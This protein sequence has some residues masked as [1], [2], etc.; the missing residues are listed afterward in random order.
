M[1]LLVHLGVTTHWLPRRAITCSMLSS[2]HQS[3]ILVSRMWMDGWK[4]FHPFLNNWGSS[5]QR[6][7][8]DDIFDSSH[9]DRCLVLFFYRSGCREV[10]QS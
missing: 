5:I 2:Q 6:S 1:E 3:K 4:I 8:H 7:N 10:G 9:L